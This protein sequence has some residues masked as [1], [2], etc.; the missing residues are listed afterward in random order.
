MYDAI[1]AES[2]SI[3]GYRDHVVEAYLSRPMRPGPIGSV[4]V[5]HHMPGYDRSTK[6]I[7]RRF[8]EGG[9]AAICPNLYHR[10]A[11]GADSDDAAAAA[12]A[13]GG[14]PDERLIGDMFGAVRYLRGLT[15]SN[16][17]VGI[18]GY[19]S[20]GRQA[21]LAA[22]HLDLQAAVD[23]YGAFVARAPSPE[24]SSRVRPIVEHLPQLS[25]PLLGLFGAEDIYPTPEEVVDLEQALAKA[26]KD[27]DFHTYEGAGHAFFDV[28]RPGYRPSAATDGWGRILKFFGLHLSN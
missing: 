20:G 8:A 27:F 4:V 14:V 18:I 5:I 25:C 6:E 15:S 12:R 10:E 1:L 26:G 19:C 2:T 24:M 9:F 3:T 11:P 17:R 13:A 28:D 16:G 23:C 21:L 22:C 7:T